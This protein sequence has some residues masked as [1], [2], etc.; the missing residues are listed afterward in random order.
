MKEEQTGCQS[1]KD[2]VVQTA[3]QITGLLSAN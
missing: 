1:D 2:C 3:G